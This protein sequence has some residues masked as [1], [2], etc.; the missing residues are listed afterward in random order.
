MSKTKTLLQIAD[1]YGIHVST[2][3]RWLKPIKY[4]LKVNNRKLLLPWQINMIYDYLN[5]RHSGSEVS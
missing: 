4:Q 3:H 1:E 2:L 5:N